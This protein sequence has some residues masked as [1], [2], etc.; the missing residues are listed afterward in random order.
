V[1]AT[2]AMGRLSP[3]IVQTS[4]PV[5][6]AFL[7]KLAQDVMADPVD[8]EKAASVLPVLGEIALSIP[9]ETEEHSVVLREG[10]PTFEVCSTMCLFPLFLSDVHIAEFGGHWLC[11]QTVL[12]RCI[13]L[14]MTGIQMVPGTL[15]IAS[16]TFFSY[17]AKVSSFFQC[18]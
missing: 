7:N 3:F 14:A 17:L 16:Y 15:T 5:L 8:Y 9:P 6:I 12:K 1:V 2:N 13:D 18:A 10:G 11:L 4:M